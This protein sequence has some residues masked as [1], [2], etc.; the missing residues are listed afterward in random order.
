[1]E[2]KKENKIIL[3][4]EARAKTKESLYLFKL[5][6]KIIQEAAN[7]NENQVYFDIHN[8]NS[9]VVSKLKTELLNKGYSV[10][11]LKE[12]DPEGVAESFVDYD[13]LVIRW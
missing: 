2:E 1:M 9:D 13:V 12:E 3:A 7:R 8:K 4:E 5:A 10:D 11:F 6:G